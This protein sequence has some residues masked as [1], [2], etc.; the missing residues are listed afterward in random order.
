MQECITHTCARCG[1]DYELEPPHYKRKW[2]RPCRLEYARIYNRSYV[3]PETS[4]KCKCATCGIDFIG[5]RSRQKYCSDRCRYF[6][7]TCEPNR[8]DGIKRTCQQH[9]FPSLCL[10]CGAGF[11]SNGVTRYCG[12]RCRDAARYLLEKLRQPQFTICAW[13][14]GSFPYRLNKQ[15]CSEVCRKARTQHLKQHRAP[16]R[17]H[18][19]ICRDCGNQHGAS[20][21]AF[22]ARKFRCP[23]CSDIQAKARERS[24]WG[25][26]DAKRRRREAIMREGD[27]IDVVALADMY[28]WICHLCNESINADF[29]WPHPGS[30]TLDHVIP[31]TPRDPN[32]EPG[33][34]TWDNVRPAHS[35]CNSRRGNRPIA[36]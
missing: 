31:L 19:P 34:H 33:T 14:F 3:A 30:L 8:T 4:R 18:L 27:Q 29:K 25:K 5:N 10:W 7:T 23:L 12:Q 6:C 1:L 15:C 21:E 32:A 24:K 22:S 13:C 28:G 2:C 20:L 9:R 35:Q 16:D 17:C 36:V 11:I 26:R